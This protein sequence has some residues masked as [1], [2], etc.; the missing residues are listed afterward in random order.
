MCVFFIFD[1]VSSSYS[2][3]P[4]LYSGFKFSQLEMSMFIRHLMTTPSLICP[5]SLET[6]LAS[7]IPKLNFSISQEIAWN[8]SVIVVPVIA[9]G[10]RKTPAMPLMVSLVDEDGGGG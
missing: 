1:R 7:L 3:I 10:D 9:S 8:M 4:T 2:L 5:R 6:V